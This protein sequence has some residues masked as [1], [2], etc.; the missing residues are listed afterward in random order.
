MIVW[1]LADI[2]RECGLP[3]R[4]M[5]KQSGLN[6]NTVCALAAHTT[7]LRIDLATLDKLCAALEIQPGKLLVWVEEVQA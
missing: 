3:R 1:Q 4:A 6:L 7:H 2:L 5:A